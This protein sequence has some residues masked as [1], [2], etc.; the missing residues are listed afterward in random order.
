MISLI[1]TRNTFASLEDI[2]RRL[3]SK[4]LM[5][6]WK[7]N[8]ILKQESTLFISFILLLLKGYGYGYCQFITWFGD[9]VCL[10]VVPKD[11]WT[12]MFCQ[13]D[14]REQ[15]IPLINPAQCVPSSLQNV[16]WFTQ[17]NLT[18]PQNLADESTWTRELFD[19]RHGICPK[20]YTAG[21]SFNFT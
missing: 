17:I 14:C 11:L 6:G 7:E 9:V 15:K 3:W 4:R 8:K 21:F 12:Y 19:A 5:T 1:L 16:N 2:A 20:I 13:R 10:C 18:H